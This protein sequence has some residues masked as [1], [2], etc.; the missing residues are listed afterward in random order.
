MYYNNWSRYD[1]DVELIDDTNNDYLI[2]LPAQILSKNDDITDYASILLL[3]QIKIIDGKGD[4]NYD[5]FN[6]FSIFV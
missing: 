6:I 3:K 4:T 2:G 1:H 5:I